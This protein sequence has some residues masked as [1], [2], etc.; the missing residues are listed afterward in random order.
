[1]CQDGCASTT[2]HA[3]SSHQ[4]MLCASELCLHQRDLPTTCPTLDEWP[5]PC[6]G[7][8]VV[9]AEQMYETLELHYPLLRLQEA[10]YETRVVGPQKEQTYMSKHGYPVQ[11]CMQCVWL[12]DSMC[13]FMPP[14]V[15]FGCC[16]QI[17]PTR[18][19]PSHSGYRVKVANNRLWRVTPSPR[20]RN[21]WEASALRKGGRGPPS[22]QGE[23]GRTPPN[24]KP[25][26]R[27]KVLVLW[28]PKGL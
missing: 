2:S 24:S 13:I 7:V 1:M 4:K 11:A 21:L 20:G 9:F 3:F 16:P 8:A 27:G 6:T 12:P 14:L 28:P 23:G 22:Q 17:P 18:N 25:Q 15:S 10:G 26:R 5:P 19:P